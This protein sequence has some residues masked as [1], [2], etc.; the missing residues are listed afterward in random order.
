MNALRI[1]LLSL[2]IV[3]ISDGCVWVSNGFRNV[4]S[5]LDQPFATKDLLPVKVSIEFLDTVG[6]IDS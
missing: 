4:L 3:S 6:T 1:L 5:I 2:G